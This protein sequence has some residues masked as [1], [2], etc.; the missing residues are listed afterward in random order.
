MADEGRRGGDRDRRKGRSRS[1][2]RQ[3]SRRGEEDG[4]GG[5]A[6]GITFEQQREKDRAEAEQRRQ[7]DEED[8]ERR[9]LAEDAARMDRTVMVVGLNVKADER[10]IFEFFVGAA[11]KVRDVQIIRDARTGRSKG[12]AYVEF[13]SHEGTTKALGMSGQTMK[14]AAIRVQP[15]QSDG[16]RTTFASQSVFRSPYAY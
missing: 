6:Q 12:V 11:G 10:D 13:Q 7:A 3:R 16:G 5:S 1:R 14:G 15:S 2:S 4:A 8:E 9:R